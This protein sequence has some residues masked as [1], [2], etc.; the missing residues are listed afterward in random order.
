MLLKIEKIPIY[1]YKK[2]TLYESELNIRLFTYQLSCK[3]TPNIDLNV[4]SCRKRVNVNIKHQS[5]ESI[6]Y[7]F[8]F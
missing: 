7:F 8:N 5:G 2:T 4:F 1:L 3:V 6:K